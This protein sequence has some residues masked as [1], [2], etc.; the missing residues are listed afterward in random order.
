MFNKECIC[1]CMNFTD[2]KMHGKTIKKN[3]VNA[4]IPVSKP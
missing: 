3:K 4:F 2:I 1:W